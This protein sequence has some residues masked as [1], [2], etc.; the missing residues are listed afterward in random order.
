LLGF[1]IDLEFGKLTVPED[2]LSCLCDLLQL[3]LEKHLFPAR[4]LV[5]AVG[6]IISM[7]LALGP[8]VQLMTP[9]L[10]AVFS[11]RILWCTQLQLSYEVKQELRFWLTRIQRFNGQNLWPKP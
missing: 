2:K 10:N 8:V 11:T 3:L 9:T 5:S 7:S 6:R 4:L 1:T